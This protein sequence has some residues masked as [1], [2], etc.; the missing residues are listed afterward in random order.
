KSLAVAAAAGAA[1]GGASRDRSGPLSAPLPALSRA[2]R[3][4]SHDRD[5]RDCLRAAGVCAAP[6]D[7][8][9]RVSR[10]ERS[11]DTTTAGGT[12][13]RPRVRDLY[14]PVPPQALPRDP[15]ARRRAVSRS[16]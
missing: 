14:L 7:P 5:V 1:R 3:P 12:Q 2:D 6:V 15:P 9:V 16:S 8:G 13:A 10:L 4:P 11:R